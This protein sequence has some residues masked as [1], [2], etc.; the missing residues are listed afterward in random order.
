[1]LSK[2]FRTLTGNDSSVFNRLKNPSRALTVS[3]SKPYSLFILVIESVL[4]QSNH[5]VLLEFAHSVRSDS[6][7]P[8]TTTRVRAF[9]YANA[10]RIPPVRPKPPM[11]LLDCTRQLFCRVRATANTHV[12]SITSEQDSTFPALCC[13]SLMKPVGLSSSD[14]EVVASFGI[15]L[16]PLAR[17]FKNLIFGVGQIWRLHISHSPLWLA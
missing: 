6:G 1:M 3:S 7:S 15:S 5:A 17:P 13:T 16:Y 9:P 10:S 14:L 2:P 11:G 12:Q 4:V 8:P